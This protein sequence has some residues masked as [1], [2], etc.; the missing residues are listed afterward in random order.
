MIT[1]QTTQEERTHFLEQATA[2]AF[3]AHSIDID[4]TPEQVRAAEG[5][6]QRRYER[7]CRERALARGMLMGR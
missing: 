1:A 7:K 2:E 4:S 5:A 3:R 6:A